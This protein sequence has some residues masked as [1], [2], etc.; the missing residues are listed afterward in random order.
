MPCNN[1]KS[2]KK[3]RLKPLFRK[4]SFGK[5]TGGGQID[6]SP[7]FYRLRIKWMKGKLWIFISTLVI[8]TSWWISKYLDLWD[9]QDALVT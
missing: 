7:A 5:T 4:Y 6:P 1:M 2:H 9:L 3:P 8:R